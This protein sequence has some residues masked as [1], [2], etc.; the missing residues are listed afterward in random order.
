VALYECVYILNEQAKTS[1]EIYQK[2][3]HC[4][5]I[6]LNQELEKIKNKNRY[7]SVW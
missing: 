4:Q 1:A 7:V 2:I 6:A 3:S 5:I